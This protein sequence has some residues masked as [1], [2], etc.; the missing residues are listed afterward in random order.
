L[1][2]I[3][4]APRSGQYKLELAGVQLAKDGGLFVTGIDREVKPL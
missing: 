2:V 4:S 1:N 3:I